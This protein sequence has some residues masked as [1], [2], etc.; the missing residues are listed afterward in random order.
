MVLLVIII[1][2]LVVLG[3]VV[4]INKKNQGLIEAGD[5]IIRKQNIFRLRNCFFTTVSD[6]S[7]IGESLDKEALS[8]NK[9][10]Y[11]PHF[12]EGKIVFHNH[13]FGG[14]FGA[15]I[16]RL[17]QDNATGLKRYEYQIRAW[18]A[19]RY[20]ENAADQMGAQILLTAI[21]KAILRLDCNAY[22]ERTIATFSS[23]P[24]F[25]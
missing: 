10:S 3:V 24:D 13:A 9:L 20:G 4:Y 19:R 18:K 8:R 14:T 15:S 23:K 25:L 5:I 17:E 1:M 12:D 21:E 11:E 6:I 7:E 2:I 16:R 22:V